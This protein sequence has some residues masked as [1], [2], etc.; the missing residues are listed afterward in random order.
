MATDTYTVGGNKTVA[1]Q[2]VWAGNGPV[3]I[4]NTDLI[5]TIFIGEDNSIRANDGN[6]IVPIGPNGSVTVDGT[7]DFFAVSNASQPV[8]I[9]TISGGLAT[10]LGL[11]NGS[12]NLVLPSM[13]SPNFV[14]NLSGWRIDKQ[15][16]AQFNSITLNGA[17]IAPGSITAA[18]I[19][20]AAGILGTMLANGT[21]TNAQIAAN[22]ITAVQLAAGIVYAGI[23]N[24]TTI[25]GANFIAFG[26]SNQ[27]LVYQG[28]PANGNLIGSWS[29]VSGTDPLGNFFQAGI[30]IY[31]NSGN[32]IGMVPGGGGSASS[33]QFSA[34]SGTPSIVSGCSA[35]FANSNG[36]LI[37]N[38][39][40]DGQTYA[41]E[42]KTKGL[43]TGTIGTTATTL[44][45]F[46]VSARTY[47][48]SARIFFTA[49]GAGTQT[50]G[51][52]FNCSGASVAN[53]IDITVKRA[54]SLFG[55]TFTA[56]LN[57][58]VGVTAALAAGNTYVA[59]IEGLITFGSGGLNVQ[60]IVN[61]G[62]ASLV[63]G[64][65]ELKPV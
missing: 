37:V 1:T 31:D 4:V 24:G 28:T 27:I 30:W 11:T 52:N 17:Q 32:A 38:D 42:R 64:Y 8:T 51:F 26:T 2:I 53:G 50:A 41:I 55:A 40:G 34:G 58:T 47:R 60:M 36:E 44:V 57:A 10:F 61:T 3:L 16:N 59:E 12:G 18:Q 65:V 13:Q 21:I 49:G 22:T 35:L 6:G 25:S 7:R 39:V 14:L 54:T 43:G 23:V 5:N 19:N 46:T 56:T 29:A 20:S 33:I 63:G 45:N 62:T 48:I 15:G 9:A